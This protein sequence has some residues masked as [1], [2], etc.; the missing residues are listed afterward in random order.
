MTKRLLL[1]EDEPHARA[2]IHRILS[3][4]F[5]K[6]EIT[7][8]GSMSEACIAS[9]MP[10]AEPFDLLLL[11]VD[12]GTDQPSGIDFAEAY[13]NA[14]TNPFTWI[15]FLTGHVESFHSALHRSKVCEFLLKPIEPDQL[16]ATV[17]RLLSHRVV[18]A[19]SPSTLVFKLKNV[20]F[21]IHVEEIEYIEMVQKDCVIF[22]R[23][24]DWS[25]PRFPLKKLSES[26]PRA[27]F[28]QCHKSF[29]VNIHAVVCLHRSGQ[30]GELELRGRT[31]RIPV[32][33]TFMKACE[34]FFLQ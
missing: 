34:Q 22:T 6:L 14:S 30:G 12:L 8:A 11:D 19:E 31:S 27:S 33:L 15:V 25:I 2:S 7:T 3:N 20:T 28:I 32:G 23:T 26:L 21:R 29:W 17:E 10:A 4:H 18:P 1:L 16:V 5:P 13:R 9:G 24:R